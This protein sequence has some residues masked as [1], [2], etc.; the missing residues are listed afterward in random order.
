M[1]LEIFGIFIVH[2]LARKDDD[3]SL[4]DVF[5]PVHDQVTDACMK[6]SLSYVICPV[7]PSSISYFMGKNMLCNP[8]VVSARLAGISLVIRQPS[9]QV[10]PDA[11]RFLVID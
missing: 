10:H 7:F 5:G 6:L 1:G 2:L 8:K 3:I 9:D 4:N 11:A